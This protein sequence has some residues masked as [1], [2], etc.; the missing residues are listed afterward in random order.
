MALTKKTDKPEN[1]PSSLKSKPLSEVRQDVPVQDV[2]EEA[3]K[4]RVNFEVPKEVRQAW[5]A[6]ALER[7][8]SLSDLIIN[9]VN[10]YLSK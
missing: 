4:V 10:E 8:V 2:Q 3:K 5:K 6:A 1:K 9:A 7:D